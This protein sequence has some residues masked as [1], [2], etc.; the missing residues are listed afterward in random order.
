MI[1]SIRKLERVEKSK[2]IDLGEPVMFSRAAGEKLPLQDWYVWSI[3]TEGLSN[4]TIY[5]MRWKLM[6]P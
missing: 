1:R 5:S 6:P 2:D 3:D 4:P